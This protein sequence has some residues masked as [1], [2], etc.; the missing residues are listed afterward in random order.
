VN[1]VTDQVA[2]HLGNTRTVCRKYY[3]HPALFELYETGSLHSYIQRPVKNSKDQRF[4][5]EELI[6][7]KILSTQQRRKTL[8]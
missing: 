2:R 5:S 8:A 4:T 1:W 6:M 7:I 3:I